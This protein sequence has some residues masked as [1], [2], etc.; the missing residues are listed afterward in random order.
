MLLWDE[1]KSMKDSWAKSVVSL[2]ESLQTWHSFT[3]SLLIHIFLNVS[4]LMFINIFKTNGKKNKTPK[5]ARSTPLWHLFRII[6]RRN[7]SCK[8]F[9]S[10]WHF[11]AGLQW[12]ANR[13][14]SV[15]TVKL[16]EQRMR[17]KKRRSSLIMSTRWDVI[18]HF[19]R[20]FDL[21]HHRLLIILPDGDLVHVCFTEI[22]LYIYLIA[23]VFW[24][25]RAEHITQT[26]LN[27]SF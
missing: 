11:R 8:R 15:D 19:K 26:V 13:F 18:I 4:L 21:K 14:M 23:E 16:S 27:S 6:H 10:Q 25:L 3:D 9:N 5:T 22:S 24:Y 2:S 17:K 12:S 7:E 20:I 1:A